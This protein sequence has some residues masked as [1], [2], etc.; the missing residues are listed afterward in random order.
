[1]TAALAAKLPAEA[2]RLNENVISISQKGEG[3]ELELG[4]NTT[5]LARRVVLAIPPAVATKIRFSPPLPVDKA[6]FMKD[7]ATWCGDWCKVVAVF[8]KSLWRE[9]GASGAVITPGAIGTWWEGATEEEGKPSLV[10]LGVGHSVASLATLVDGDPAVRELVLDALTP[11]F[12]EAVRDSLIEVHHKSWQGD[13]ETYV[14]EASGRNYG[15]PL[16]A[17]PLEWGVHFAG[18]ET[19]QQNGHAEGAIRAGERAAKEIRVGLS[20]TQNVTAAVTR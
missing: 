20:L 4:S 17:Q 8:S 1:M 3:I 13:K 5:V 19:E 11:I 12:G 2:I 15:H 16:L 7:T 9:R 18:T 14:A 10:G 6:R